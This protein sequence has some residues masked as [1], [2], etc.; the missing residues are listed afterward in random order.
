MRHMSCVQFYAETKRK[1]KINVS[2]FIY[3]YNIALCVRMWTL[4]CLS[5]LEIVPTMYE[6]TYKKENLFSLY[7]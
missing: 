7:T 1:S 6:H 4:I 2:K 3:L 5:Y